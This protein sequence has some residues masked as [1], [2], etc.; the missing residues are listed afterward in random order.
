M[1]EDN[2]SLS[3]TTVGF[4]SKYLTGSSILREGNA[5]RYVEGVN[6]SGLNKITPGIMS[7]DIITS[8]EKL[9]DKFSNL[10]LDELADLLD[11]TISPE[12]SS[13]LYIASV[14]T[15]NNCKPFAGSKNGDLQ[16]L[17]QHLDQLIP[18]ENKTKLECFAKAELIRPPEFSLNVKIVEAL[19]LKQKYY[20][21]Y[22]LFCKMWLSNN[23]EYSK[24]TRIIDFDMH[25]VWNSS[26]RFDIKNPEGSVLII[27]IRK[28]NT[29]KLDSFSKKKRLPP[30][31]QTSGQM[32]S[33][34]SSN[35]LDE[36]GRIVGWSEIKMSDIYC[37]G[38]DTW[39]PIRS[40]KNGKPKGYLHVVAKIEPSKYYG[41]IWALKRHLMLIRICIENNFKLNDKKEMITDWKQ[42]VSSTSSSFI[43][44]HSMIESIPIWEDMISWFIMTNHLAGR[45]ND[46]SFQFMYCI[47]FACENSIRQMLRL[48][49]GIERT[50]QDMFRKEVEILNDKC[51]KFAENLH[52]YDLVENKTKR[53]EFECSLKIIQL[54]NSILKQKNDPI[55]V[56]KLEA[57]KWF[58][59]LL[60]D[61]P[62]SIE[63]R[64]EYLTDIIEHMKVFH[65]I[66]DRIIKKV[67]PEILYTSI[68]NENIEKFFQET[69]KNCICE[70]VEC[71]AHPL[72]EKDEFF[73][74]TFKLFAASKSLLFYTINDLNFISSFIE[75]SILNT[76]KTVPI[77]SEDPKTFLFD[78]SQK[79]C[80]VISEMMIFAASKHI[81]K[82]TEAKYK[83][84]QKLALKMYSVIM[85]KKL[86]DEASQC[87]TLETFDVFLMD[88]G[89]RM[90]NM[91]Q[92][93]MNFYEIKDANNASNKI[94]CNKER[95]KIVFKG[96]LDILKETEKLCTKAHQNNPSRCIWNG[97][98][99]ELEKKLISR[100]S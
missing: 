22:S 25:L 90:L 68:I 88:F 52:T 11:R 66:A 97:G 49:Y 27:E 78:A 96:L 91:I 20:Y 71:L 15:I 93:H 14:Y 82:V 33:E 38:I 1:V 47:L 35:E 8:V 74:K 41:G 34:Q 4:R 40:T 23:P 84:K 57:L 80:S 73:E 19:R 46:I 79:I 42:I 58:E 60:E 43:H 83:V 39:I 7:E 13:L 61:L 56:L 54:S 77:Q 17:H 18:L 21:N 69:L 100:L 31:V 45:Y 24:T 6:I 51:M 50:L 98:F 92:N 30:T 5:N 10:K 55:S 94:K 12:I 76:I 81:S 16:E 63:N 75:Q 37:E 9:N 53:L 87:M 99:K 85:D 32:S 3:G 67:F 86:W 48:Q 59:K 70:I 44:L 29:N 28:I 72:E 36:E 89:N 65:V 95:S 64:I 62:P 26:Y 2:K